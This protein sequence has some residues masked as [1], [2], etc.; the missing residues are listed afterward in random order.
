MS[1][2][3]W[4][5]NVALV[6]AFAIGFALD[7]FWPVI[8]P[9]EIEP[10]AKPTPMVQALDARIAVL[11]ENDRLTSGIVSLCPRVAWPLPQPQ[12]VGEMPG[13]EEDAK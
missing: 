7:Y 4:F 1:K 8:F 2:I 12:L 13:F 5:T 6:I 3:E 11:E 10:L 9:D